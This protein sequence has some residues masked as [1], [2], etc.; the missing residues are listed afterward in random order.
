M[1]RQLES[2]IPLA[3]D[4]SEYVEFCQDVVSHLRGFTNDI[5]PITGFFLQ[6]SAHYWPKRDDP[7]LYAAGINSYSLRLH[8]QGSKTSFELFHY[9]Y[10]GWK[11]D[12]LN[13]RIENHITCVQKGMKD[14][15]FTEFMLCN[16]VPAAVLIG[17][18]TA[19]GWILPSTYLPL[20]AK[21]SSHY[22]QRNGPEAAT[23]FTHLI[24]ILKIIW[25]SIRVRAINA[26]VP[27]DLTWWGQILQQKE[28]GIN[29]AHQGII[30]IGCH[31]W[32]SIQPVLLDYAQSHPT[33]APILDEI[34]TPMNDFLRKAAY[35][36]GL[37]KRDGWDTL[38]DDQLEVATGEFV[39][40]FVAALE[41]DISN[42]EVEGT[43][44]CVRVNIGN[45]SVRVPS[46]DGIL[47]LDEVLKLGLSYFG[48]ISEEE[49]NTAGLIQ[50]ADERDDTNTMTPRYPGRLP[51]TMMTSP[52][53]KFP[54]VF[55]GFF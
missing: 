20:L 29:V 35:W 10:S 6:H 17:F 34:A 2:V 44:K 18:S 40:R 41:D 9:L 4:H 55:R 52:V 49:V 13:S 8:D 22:L 45:R 28:D 51:K 31:F 21:R 50:V 39:E 14:W 11:N 32:I 25:N 19:G 53:E 15:S 36:L 7:H 27:R 43:Q 30:S 24:N 37:N 47:T 26:G 54:G 16:F 12:H 3:P 42:W 33:E 5:R 46:D 38:N 48:G 23:T 1:Q